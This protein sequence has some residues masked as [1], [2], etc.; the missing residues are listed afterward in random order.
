MVKVSSEIVAKFYNN[1]FSFDAVV[2]SWLHI[3]SYIS[4]SW[5]LNNDSD[6]RATTQH[7][8][9]VG[10]DDHQC[11]AIINETVLIEQNLKRTDITSG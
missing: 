1:Y 11:G 4:Q 2:G 8:Q 7:Q 9:A 10:E 5:R 6:E 3:F